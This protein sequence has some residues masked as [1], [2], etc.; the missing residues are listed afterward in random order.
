[1]KLGVFAIKN[2]AQHKVR[3]ILTLLSIV[4]AVAVLF[5]LLSFNQG[6]EAA[7]KD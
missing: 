5:T 1:M 3:T 6:Y 7:L 4:A 2:L